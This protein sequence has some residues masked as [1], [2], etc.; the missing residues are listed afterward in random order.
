MNL[1]T[2]TGCEGIDWQTVA[3]ILKLVG[4]A[5]HAPEVLARAFRASHTTVFIH[6]GDKLVGFGRAIS[7]GAYQAAVYDCAVLPEYQGHGL[8]A[9]IMRAILDGVGECNVILY[10]AP[11]KEGFYRKQGFSNMK[12]GMARFVRPAVM[13]EKGFTD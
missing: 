5:S 1:R 8:G 4:M 13:R 10:A 2:T 7:D 12:T 9:A 6:D 3:D 11:G